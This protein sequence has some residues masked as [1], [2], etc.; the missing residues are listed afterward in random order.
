MGKN[1]W[2]VE[3]NEGPTKTLRTKTSI[4]KE[5]ALIAAV[6]YGKDPLPLT[7]KIWCPKVTPDYGPYE[8]TVD[9][10]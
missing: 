7:V 9:A 10:W 5:A 1:V 2:K 8:Y 3:V 4:Y 6:K